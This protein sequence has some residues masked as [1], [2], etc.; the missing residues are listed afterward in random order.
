[1][2]KK[3]TQSIKKT[4]ANQ[5]PQDTQAAEATTAQAA[6]TSTSVTAE[7]APISADGL[8]L[9]LDVIKQRSKTE[10]DALYDRLFDRCL[11]AGI[12]PSVVASPASAQA[13]AATIVAPPVTPAAAVAPAASAAPATPVATPVATAPSTVSAAPAQAAQKTNDKKTTTTA[14]AAKPKEVKD[15]KV[16]KEEKVADKAPVA[17]VTAPAPAPKAAAPVTT[18]T[19]APALKAEVTQAPAA[20][21]VEA[22]AKTPV[23]KAETVIKAPVATKPA[24]T[25][26]AVAK[27]PTA[28]K[29]PTTVSSS[30]AKTAASIVS[31]PAAA[32]AKLLSAPAAAKKP[33]TVS[34]AVLK[35]PMISQ[36]EI[37]TL[38]KEEP[39]VVASN[40]V[41]VSEGDEVT[42]PSFLT[43]LSTCIKDV[44]NDG[45]PEYKLF[46]D[47]IKEVNRAAKKAK[48]ASSDGEGSNSISTEEFLNNYV[49]NK[50]P[51]ES[52]S[53]V[54]SPAGLRS[55]LGAKHSERLVAYC[56]I[57]SV[58][59]ADIEYLMKR[60][61]YDD[62]DLDHP[63]TVEPGQSLSKL[64][65]VMAVGIYARTMR[66]VEAGGTKLSS[67]VQEVV[68]LAY[69][70]LG[71]KDENG[72]PRSVSF[73]SG[74]N[75]ASR[76]FSG[77]TVERRRGRRPKAYNQ[78]F[79]SLVD[80]S[81][82]EGVGSQMVLGKAQ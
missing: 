57:L 56:A 79:K 10:Q 61:V 64:S 54:S 23:V 52:H 71:S 66:E 50:D 16:V 72:E 68:A 37:D 74:V 40:T 33:V 70:S 48:G 76:I 18:A 32:V 46:G 69:D 6:P 3:T 8:N 51:A 24:E 42:D 81:G 63:Y 77:K 11:A 44:H 78:Q 80:S 19:K 73:D 62:K 59:K 41:V 31:N 38:N 4:S 82:N 22:V 15:V 36:S 58:S 35:G 39:K 20:K 7:P 27:A 9:M 49:K 13:P 47:R 26:A 53:I 21:T 60:E 75:Y 1:M 67:S 25:K 45:Q 29:A 5:A 55:L 34:A 17:K 43:Y 2:E 12:V 28:A 30:A 14:K 65:L